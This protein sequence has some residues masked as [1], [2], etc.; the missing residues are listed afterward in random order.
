MYAT[1]LVCR[2]GHEGIAWWISCSS[3]NRDVVGSI[4][5]IAGTHFPERKLWIAFIAPHLVSGFYQVSAGGAGSAKKLLMRRSSVLGLYGSGAEYMHMHIF[6][7][8]RICGVVYSTKKERMINCWFMYV[9]IYNW[10]NA[11]ERSMNIKF[12]VDWVF[13]IRSKKLHV[14]LA[15]LQHT[16]QSIWR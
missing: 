15:A 8:Q 2:S 3:V 14:L 16:R 6:L 9:C 13:G 4:L 12:L 1:A 5:V 10:Y 7:P 11:E